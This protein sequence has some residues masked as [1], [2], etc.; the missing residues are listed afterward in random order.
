MNLIIFDI[1]GTIVNS[2]KVDDECFKETFKTLYRIDLS[3]T[4]WIDFKNVTDSGITME[5]F[6]KYLNRVPTNGEIVRIKKHFYE[7]LVNRTKEFFEIDGALKFIERIDKNPNFITAFATGGWKETALLKVNSIKLKINQSIIKT[8]DDHFNR[9][10][11]IEL[12]IAESLS[13]VKIPEFE[14]I[15]YI[16]DGI[17]DF[18]TANEMGIDFIG[19]D[20]K[21]NCQLK[22]AGVE[23]ILSNYLE[24]DK[25]EN[26]LKEKTTGNKV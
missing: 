24:T 3:Q 12:A 18:E 21:N 20:S 23:K 13:K 1:D 15:T 8:A 11:I 19:I 16:G 5:I 6:E 2:V 10:K 26:W 14:S 17:W 9:T 22:M 7:L 4:K 25:I